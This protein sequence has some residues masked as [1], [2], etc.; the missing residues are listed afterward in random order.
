MQD[1]P[2]LP[3]NGMAMTPFGLA[4]LLNEVVINSRTDV[5]EFGSGIST[6]LLARLGL[7]NE[8]SLRITSIDDDPDWIEYLQGLLQKENLSRYV[9]FIHAPKVRKSYFQVE[10][11]DWYDENILNGKLIEQQFDLVLVDGPKAMER[12]IEMNRYPAY[13]FILPYLKPAYT[14]FL[15]DANRRGE[16]QILN[17]WAHLAKGAHFS[18]INEV[19]GVG[20]AGKYFDATP[21]TR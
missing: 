11:L 5:V 19:V 15:D 14:I 13:P 7:V 3:F 4:F 8:L 16:K 18:V 10:N 20:R 6:L 1:R 12:N 21:Y 9:D 2:Y 17:K